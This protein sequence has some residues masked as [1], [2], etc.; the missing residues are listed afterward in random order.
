MPLIII[1]KCSA[2]A[3]A[4]TES[5]TA[6]TPRSE[7]SADDFPLLEE[8][9]SAPQKGCWHGFTHLVGGMWSTREMTPI[10][11]DKEIYVRTTIRELVVYCIFIF[12]LCMGNNCSILRCNIQCQI[13]PVTFGMT[14]QTHFYY[15]KVMVDLFNKQPE[16]KN[17]EEF[18]KFMEGQLL[19]GLYW[20]YW[21][22]E[23]ND[24]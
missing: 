13:F 21:Y 22:N 7:G 16:I 12:V 17:H 4:W 3:K 8:E 18:W 15:T 2:S 23:G 11:V 1:V 9:N 24:K 14:S 10:N 19:D 5:E 20:E 6:T